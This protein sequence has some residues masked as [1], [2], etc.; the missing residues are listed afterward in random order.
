MYF[1]N[2]YLASAIVVI[3]AQFGVSLDVCVPINMTAVTLLNRDHY[4]GSKHFE[5]NDV[6]NSELSSL[7]S[8]YTAAI[9]IITQCDE[10]YI[11]GSWYKLDSD[12]IDNTKLYIYQPR[13]STYFHHISYVYNII[14]YNCTLV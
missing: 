4:I 1:V 3:I 2:L 5:C 8:S 9:Y 7:T 13:N 12:V 14:G 6:R 10:L 11:L